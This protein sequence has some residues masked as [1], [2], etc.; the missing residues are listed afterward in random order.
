MGLKKNNVIYPKIGTK[1]RFTNK[2]DLV[3]IVAC[4]LY[5]KDKEQ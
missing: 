3:F 1:V 4:Q 5:D 2:L